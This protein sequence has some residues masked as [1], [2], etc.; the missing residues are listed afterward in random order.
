MDRPKSE[1]EE[2]ARRLVHEEARRPFDLG[3]GPLFRA[4]LIRLAHDDHI[5]VLTMH[6]IVSDGW[7]MG[8]LY[9]ELSAVYRAF[10]EGRA[11]PLQELA[12]QYAD[13]AVRQREWLQGEVLENQLSY[14]KKQLE[15]IPGVLNLPTDHPRP[16]VQSYRGARRSI[17]LSGELTQGLKALSRKEGVTLF[18]TLLAAFQTLLHR[19]T[20]QED[21]VVGSP[22]ANRNRTEIEGLI[23]FFVNTL[24][25]RTNFSGNPTFKELLARVREMALGAYAHQDL[26]FEKLVEELKPERSL[27]HSPLFQVLFNMVG[28]GDFKLDLLGITTERFSFPEAQSKFDLTLYVAEQK[29]QID[30][31]LVYKVDLFSQARMKCFLDQY[32]HLLEQIV[33]VPQDPIQSYSLVTPESRE[34]LPDPSAVLAEPLQQ[35]VT[36]LFASW[37][38]R[39][40]NQPAIS[41]G[42][43][44]WTYSELAE[45][46]ETLA[47]FLRVSGVERGDVVAIHGRRSFGL[48]AGMIGTLSS[49]AVLLPIDPTL[50][51][52]RKQLMLKEAGAKRLL[53]VG[54]KRSDDAWLEGNFTPSIVV[55]DPGKGFVVDADAGLNLELVSLP[56]LSP[57]DPA[58][59]FFTSG[60]TGIPKGV[61]G[62][63]KG[64]SHFLAW[65]RETFV[66]EPHDRIAQLTGLSFDACLRDIFLPLISGATLCLPEGHDHLALDEIIAWLEREQI[67]VLHTVPSVAQ[68]WLAD[69]AAKISLPNLRRVFFV[70]ELL[71]NALV[72]RWRAVFQNAAEIVNLYGPTE[73]T[74]VKC[75]Y[76]VP[77][78][79]RSGVQPVGRTMPQAQALV[80]AQ[81]NRLCGIN[82]PGEIVLRTPFRSLGYINAP[83]ENA[84]RFVKNPF[85]DDAHDL[86]YFTGDAGR[87][88]LDGTLEILGRL[89]D[90]VKIRGVRIE[91]AEVT[92]ILAQHPLVDSCIVVAKKNADDDSSLVAYLVA[93]KQG[94]PTS[95][96]LRS[97]LLER[98]QLAMLPSAFILLDALPLTSN[99]KVDR[100]ALAALDHNRPDPEESFVAPRTTLE[101]MLVAIWAEVLKSNR[102]GIH[103]NFFELGGHSL[104]ATQLVSRVRGALEVELP[105]RALFEKPTVAGLSDHIESVL[106]SG[107]KDSQISKDDLGEMEE[108]V[109]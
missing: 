97:Y 60:T 91:P 68:S 94:Q 14:W 90:Q 96:Q 72:R 35:L 45:S 50:P 59:I 25:L 24:A 71:T 105:L 22:I 4:T 106:R 41:Q 58:Y 53:Y 33:A 82:E 34:L 65:Q 76:R 43:Q 12:I 102:V 9:H 63:H 109:L 16:T 8:V 31:D 88:T 44:N 104:L 74:L 83:D 66:I 57:D 108:I 98:L 67:S 93:S 23:G 52:Q 84:K 30:F 32:R 5:L 49:G 51:D 78:D 37:A 48:I 6:H 86:V 54:D 19:Y 40:A 101:K 7:S 89:D 62:C 27:S 92:A 38:M 95:T 15:G 55:V 61:L 10:S 2:G 87:Y 107:E 1:R 69:V 47:R 36:S 81:N 18:M 100:K 73:T 85:R 103:D 46:A 77:T 13:F 39:T 64:L 17:Q 42:E 21:I 80:L 26:P 3:R 56:E 29:N 79:L 75:F 99:G 28:Q 70:G 11:S 20:G